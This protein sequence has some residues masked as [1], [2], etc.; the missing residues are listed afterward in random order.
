MQA[1]CAA[2]ARL[3]Q[4]RR[5]A[6]YG[7]LAAELGLNGPGRIAHLTSQ[8]EA[9]MEQDAARGHPLRA[10][11]VIGRV[12]NGLPARGFF[13]KAQALGY[14]V[15]DPAGFHSAQLAALYETQA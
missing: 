8:L 2:L 12:S 3:A 4:D 5:C 13:D 11:L 7:A 1:L 10:A 15:S 6:S 9:L 14:D